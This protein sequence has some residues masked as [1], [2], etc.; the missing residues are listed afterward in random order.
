MWLACPTTQWATR[1]G[2]ADEDGT[3]AEDGGGTAFRVTCQRPHAREVTNETVGMK[4]LCN[5]IG[6]FL[7][8]AA[9]SV[10]LLPMALAQHAPHQWDRGS[11]HKFGEEEDDSEPIGRSTL[12]RQS[13][14]ILN[15]AARRV[16]GGTSGSCSGASYGPSYGM[17][18]TAGAENGGWSQPRRDPATWNSPQQPSMRPKGT[19]P[20]YLAGGMPS[21]P[22]PSM[23]AAPPRGTYGMAGVGGSCGGGGG[24]KLPPPADWKLTEDMM[25]QPWG[26]PL[27]LT[28]SVLLSSY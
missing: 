23:G 2:G 1:S 9:V 10:S 7:R 16:P 28:A 21:F 25:H 27:P 14:A 3:G 19:P 18:G 22:Q 26:A 13:Q 12:K 15:Q 11:P 17:G 20:H 24:G 5:E 6:V 4:P 8:P